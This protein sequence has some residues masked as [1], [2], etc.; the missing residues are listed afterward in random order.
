MITAN[1]LA[2]LLETNYT[3]ASVMEAADMLRQQ[4]AEIEALKKEAALQRLS[5]FTQEADNEPVAWMVDGEVYLLNEIDGEE[6]N[7]IP[8]YTHPAKNNGGNPE[9][10]N[11]RQIQDARTSLESTPP[12]AYAVVSKECPDGM[13]NMSLQFNEPVDAKKVIPLY[14]H[15]AKP[16]KVKFASDSCESGWIYLDYEEPAK[17]LTDEEIIKLFENPDDFNCIEFARAI[18]RKAQEK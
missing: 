13:E 2:D 16:T 11:T 10:L 17:T 12:F 6:L 7:A 1:E 5:D 8:L 15:P 9:E 14:T 4:Q 3:R 18:L